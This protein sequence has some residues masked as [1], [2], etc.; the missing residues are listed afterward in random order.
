MT[1]GWVKLVQ[2]LTAQFGLPGSLAL[3]ILC[4]VMYL[5][6]EER[7]AHSATRDKVDTINERRIELH[8]TYLVAF[9]ELKDSIQAIQAILG[10]SK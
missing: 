5:L 3:A 8:A 10:K 7:K 4:Y 9:K 1:E 6:G 2:F